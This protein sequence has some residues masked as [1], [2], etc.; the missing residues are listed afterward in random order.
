MT[1]YLETWSNA[2]EERGMRVSR[3]KT[4]FMGFMFERNEEMYI[5]YSKDTWRRAGKSDTLQISRV[6]RGRERRHGKIIKQ[7]VIAVWINWNKCSGSLYDRKM[8]VKLKE[9][10]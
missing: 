3:P 5:L 1:G 8:P 4:Q 9:N 10:T 6:I 2:Q 7:R